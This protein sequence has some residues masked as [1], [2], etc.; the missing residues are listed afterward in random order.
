MAAGA[1]VLRSQDSLQATL[2]VLAD[3]AGQASTDPCTDCWEATNVL[4]VA[5]ALADQRLGAAG[6]PRVATGAR[7]SPSATTR[8]GRYGSTR[9]LVDGEVRLSEEDVR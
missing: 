6:D 3:V 1:G 7:T 8:A 9:P 2:G 5:T 4:T